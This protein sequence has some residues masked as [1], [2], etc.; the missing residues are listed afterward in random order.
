MASAWLS[1][2]PRQV[3][4]VTAGRWRVLLSDQ[5]SFCWSQWPGLSFWLVVHPGRTDFIHLGRLGLASSGSHAGLGK[6]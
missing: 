1:F 2:A 4:P 3:I 6:A 5:E